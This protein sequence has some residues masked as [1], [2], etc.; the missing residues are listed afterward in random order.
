MQ[1]R[2]YFVSRMLPMLFLFQ[3]K[4]TSLPG[5][6]SL[7]QRVQNL[8]ILRPAPPNVIAIFRRS[9]SFLRDT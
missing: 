7:G 9:W 3:W 4:V 8:P 1:K 6:F 2:L 5:S